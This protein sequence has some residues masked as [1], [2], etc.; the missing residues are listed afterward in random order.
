MRRL[1]LLVLVALGIAGLSAGAS[2]GGAGLPIPTGSLPISV[3]VSVPSLPLP[4][5]PPPPAPPPPPPP[6]HQPPPPPPSPPPSPGGRPVP[7]PH[8]RT[9]R[10]HAAATRAAPHQT[11]TAPTQRP[12]KTHARRPAQARADFRPPSASLPHGVL[13][14][15]SLVPTARKL[16]FL[17]LAL[18]GI[19]ILLLA[20]GVLPASA[21]P[22][23]AAAELLAERRLAVALGGLATLVAAVAAYLLA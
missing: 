23:P 15:E 6:P 19:A 2:I 13:A 20:L 7:R 5:P 17:V 22:H 12:A 8:H 14:P 1:R 16:P 11:A 4:Q 18:V 21:A 3:P 9:H 10:A